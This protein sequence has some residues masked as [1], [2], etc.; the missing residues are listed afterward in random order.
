MNKNPEK[1]FLEF[2][3]AVDLL[4]AALDYIE[5]AK[6]LLGTNTV[7]DAASWCLMY[8]LSELN[9]NEQERN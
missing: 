3:S 5:A 2:A 6:Q 4:I 8:V 1:E 7:L 9:E